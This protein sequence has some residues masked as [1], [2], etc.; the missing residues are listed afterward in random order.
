MEGM[1]GIEVA[2]KV[3]E[4]D[5]NVEIN[6]FSSYLNKMQDAFQLE[7]TVFWIKSSDTN[8]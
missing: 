7:H 1:N 5:E 8:H 3:R 4:T 2:K 6:I